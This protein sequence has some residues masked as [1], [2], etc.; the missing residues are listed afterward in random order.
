RVEA[1]I[2]LLY[3][4][5]HVGTNENAM[6]LFLR[7]LCDR[8]DPEDICY[9]ELSELINDL[10][11]DLEYKSQSRSRYIANNFNQ[12]F[13]LSQAIQDSIIIYSGPIEPKGWVTR[14][15]ERGDCIVMLDGLD[16]IVDS[17][18]RKQVVAWLEH[19]MIAYSKNRFILT[20]RPHG[21]F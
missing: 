10:S 3:N 11:I 9:S 13:S 16:E 1:L 12:E 21:Y 14:R 18:N 7:A 15:L 17:F 20:S 2:G 8:I 6:I 19:Q 4:N 5:Y